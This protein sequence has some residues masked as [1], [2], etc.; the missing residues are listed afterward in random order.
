MARGR[1]LSRTLGSSVRWGVTLPKVLS[2]APELIEFSQTLYSL[3]LAQS[4]DFGRQEGNIDTVR[5]RVFPTSRRTEDEFER[6]LLA[7]NE[8]ELIDWYEAQQPHSP[9]ERVIAIRKWD[10][11][12]TGLHKRTKSKFP[13]PPSEEGGASAIPAVE[14]SSDIMDRARSWAQRY[15]VAHLEIIQQPYIATRIQEERDVDAA[16]A[17]CEGYNDDQLG[18][19]VETFLRIPDEGSEL[20]KNGRRTLPMLLLMA[21]RIAK[22]LGVKPEVSS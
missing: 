22:M 21:P 8:A 5:F 18:P 1:M 11:H 2:D 14:V 17:L 13:D 6:A 20:F 3:L 9:V 19:I 16:R 15:K 10:S 12:Q 7:L 4:D